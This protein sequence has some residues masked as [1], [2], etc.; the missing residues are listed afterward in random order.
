MPTRK[1]GRL[2][3]LPL[4]LPL[5]GALA[6]AVVGEG[7]GLAWVVGEG[8][9]GGVVGVSFGG[10]GLGGGAAWVVEVGL[11]T[12]GTDDE[13]GVAEGGPCTDD[14]GRWRHFLV[15]WRLRRG[16]AGMSMGAG[17]AT[18]AAMARWWWG[19]RTAWGVARAW[20]EATKERKRTRD[21]VKDI[22]RDRR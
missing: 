20:A 7:A 16:A 17:A 9:G 11:T 1:L 4:V 13:D 12:A 10:V 3:L 5:E 14:E 21:L 8:A 15:F 18:R 6:G 19:E 2:L 22:W